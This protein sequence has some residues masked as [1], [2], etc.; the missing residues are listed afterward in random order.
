VEKK[1]GGQGRNGLASLA[2][3]AH[4]VRLSALRASVEP[5]RGFSELRIN[6]LQESVKSFL[7]NARMPEFLEELKRR[8]YARFRQIADSLPE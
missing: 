1:N 4:F 6:N 3:R 2:L 7:Y 5:T 8:R